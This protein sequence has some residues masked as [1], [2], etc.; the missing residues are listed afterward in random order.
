VAERLAVL[1]GLTAVDV[2][3]SGLALHGAGPATAGAGLVLPEGVG[4]L[5]QE[6]GEGA[7]GKSGRGRRRDLLQGSE[8]GV[9]ARSV[10]AESPS[11]DNS[12]P[13]GGQIAD[14]LEVLG[15][16]LSTCHRLSC[17]RVIENGANGLSFL[18]YSKGLYGA[19]QVLTSISKNAQL[20]S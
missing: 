20:I 18:L 17:L 12:A 9:E 11:G 6:G 13:L 10:V 1:D 3:R 16:D 19:K 14:V 2:Q 4:L 8:I 15:R 7:F 5:F